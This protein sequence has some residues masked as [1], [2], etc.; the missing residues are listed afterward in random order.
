[1]N[2][3]TIVVLA[4]KISVFAIVMSLGMRARVA[5]I[6]HLFRRPG[7]LIRA[8]TS[9]YVIMPIVAVLMVWTLHL[10][11]VI[12]AVILALSVSPIPPV[13]PKSA[14]K[15][16]G[17][18]SFT[19]GLL[20][21]ATLL[22]IVVIPVAFYVFDM[23]G[24]GDAQFSRRWLIQTILTS[25]LLPLVLGMALRSFA[26]GFSGRF[27][28]VIEKLAGIVLIVSVLPVVIALAPAMGALFGT[29]AILAPVLFVVVG[30]I[31][32]YFL[33]GPDPNDRTV[34]AMATASRH[35]GIAIALAGAN[36]DE[37][38]K[39]SVIALVILYLILSLI[40]V[41]PLLKRLSKSGR[42]PAPSIPNTPGQ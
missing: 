40:V 36:V 34:L 11:S 25:L 10:T 12:A 4:I 29:W 20:S 9:M 15:S 37:S 32:G 31:A 24:A 16:G 17:E 5:D 1:M 6:T 42:A 18:A 21:A 23:L 39:K 26:P 30:A 41:A 13:F 19:F 28:G 38:L 35:P 8:L 22:S 7:Q 3:I 27:A 33:G 2:L 14:F